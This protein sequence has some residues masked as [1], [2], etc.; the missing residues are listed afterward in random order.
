[1]QVLEEMSLARF[2]ACRWNSP[3]AS[4][5]A[6]L[7]KGEKSEKLL[8]CKTLH[9][10]HG[11]Y[12]RTALLEFM[13]PLPAGNVTTHINKEV[14]P[15]LME[16]DTVRLVLLLLTLATSY[17]DPIVYNL[18]ATFIATTRHLQSKLG[19]HLKRAACHS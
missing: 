11:A 4:T 14:M 15:L 19:K 9:I 12:H 2:S 5:L 1:M 6:N 3:P 16:T 17:P 8:V 13:G 18:E 10:S 7:A